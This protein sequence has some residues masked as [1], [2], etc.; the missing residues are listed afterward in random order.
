METVTL[1][2]THDAL[3]HV[4]ASYITN[5]MHVFSPFYAA[6]ASGDGVT[7]DV[8]SR[9]IGAATARLRR[10]GYTVEVG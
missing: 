8:T 4:D 5:E 1:T 7:V 2:V 6:Q 10:L 9:H 3:P